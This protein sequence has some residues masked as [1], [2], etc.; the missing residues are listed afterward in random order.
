M[1]LLLCHSSCIPLF[2]TEDE[3]EATAT[4]G[5]TVE[6]RRHESGSTTIGVIALTTQ[7]SDFVVLIHFVVFQDSELDFGFLLVLVRQSR[8]KRS[9]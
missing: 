5:V 9:G 8:S 1:F 6:V 7:T 4:A 2:V 3:G